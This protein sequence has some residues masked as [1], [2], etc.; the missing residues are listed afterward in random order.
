MSDGYKRGVSKWEQVNIHMC[1][2][3]GYDDGSGR[4][5]LLTKTL[6]GLKQSECEWNKELD[7]C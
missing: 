5:C 2:P 1:Q 6:Y 3:E 7:R 4:V